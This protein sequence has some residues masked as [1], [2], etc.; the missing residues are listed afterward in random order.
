MSQ[1]MQIEKNT[2][3]TPV[4][5][6]I[7]DLYQAVI[8]EHGRRPRHF[9]VLEDAT[10]VKTGINPLCGDQVLLQCNITDGV[11][12]QAKFTGQGCA[13]CMASCSLML[14][15][16]QGMLVSDALQLFH[17]FHSMLTQE[18]GEIDAPELGKLSMLQGVKEF[19]VRIKCATLAW[20][21]LQALLQ[22]D[23]ADVCTE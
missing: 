9:S 8:V 16:L 19:P 18:G 13:I 17:K 21:T 7:R 2:L 14:E 6:E 11:I 4:D 23:D 3:D 5:D 12:T 20:Q 15:K 1:I 10:H 22:G